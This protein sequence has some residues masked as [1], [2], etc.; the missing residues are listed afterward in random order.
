MEWE[1]T[2]GGPFKGLGRPFLDDSVSKLS[3]FIG[4]KESTRQYRAF[5]PETRKVERGSTF[6][7]YENERW[8]PLDPRYFPYEEI[9]F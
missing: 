7:W 4:Y 8:A 1:E 6:D 3:I 5:E 2:D 9:E